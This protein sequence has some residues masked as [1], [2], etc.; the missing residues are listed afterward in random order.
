MNDLELYNKEL[1]QIENDIARKRYEEECYVFMICAGGDIEKIFHPELYDIDGTYE[2]IK[3]KIENKE[4]GDCHLYIIAEN[5]DK[6]SMMYYD[7]VDSSL[8]ELTIPEGVTKLS[9]DIIKRLPIR[10][11]FNNN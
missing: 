9:A 6:K 1:K 8:T 11:L 2:E 10:Y 5:K 4:S 3:S 7:F